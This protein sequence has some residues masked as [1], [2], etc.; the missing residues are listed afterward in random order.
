VVSDGGGPRGRRFAIYQA[1]LAHTL[2]RGPGFSVR[3]G[4]IK[5]HMAMLVPVLKTK[6]F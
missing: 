2:A 5:P 6:A 1:A 3:N 4:L